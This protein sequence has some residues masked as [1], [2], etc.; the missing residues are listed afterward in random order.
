MNILFGVPL[1]YYRYNPQLLYKYI[2]YNEKSTEKKIRYFYGNIACACQGGR[3]V[4]FPINWKV[5]EKEIKDINDNGIG[6]YITMSKCVLTKEDILD[7]NSN[8]MMSLINVDN[9]LNGFIVS[10]DELSKH[11]HEKYPFVK[12]KMSQIRVATENPTYRPIEYYKKLLESYEEVCVDTA[13]V[14][15]LDYIKQLDCSRL[16]VVCNHSCPPNCPFRPEHQ[17]FIIEQ[18]NKYLKNN[19]Y[20]IEPFECFYKNRPKEN[21]ILT[22][23]NYKDLLNI[24]F[25]KFKISGRH[26]PNVDKKIELI[27]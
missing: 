26:D 24:G 12:Q 4:N 25:N 2:K 7:E 23:K 18:Q 15:N 5:I 27:L 10:N 22:T 17:N 14:F 13:D 21:M 8:R 19:I 11:M 20:K 1:F 3:N 9:G 16:E 6:V